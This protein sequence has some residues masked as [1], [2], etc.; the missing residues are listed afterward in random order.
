MVDS[1]SEADMGRIAPTDT[2]NVRIVE[3]AGVSIGASEEN[4]NLL[5]TVDRMQGTL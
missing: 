4:G 3:V 2:E 1:A 5:V